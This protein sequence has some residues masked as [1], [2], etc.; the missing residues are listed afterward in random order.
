MADYTKLNDYTLVEVTGVGGTADG[1]LS[2]QF[3]FAA[4]QVTTIFREVSVKEKYDKPTSVAITSQMQIQKFSDFDSMD[5]VEMMHEKLK[6]GI[7]LLGL[8]K[9]YGQLLGRGKEFSLQRPR[10]YVTLEG[11]KATIIS[12]K[13]RIPGGPNVVGWTCDYSIVDGWK[14]VANSPWHA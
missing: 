1:K 5:E 6:K 8:Q 4:K 14:I 9:G 7:L 13:N 11:G 2:R 3:N 12:A 10:L